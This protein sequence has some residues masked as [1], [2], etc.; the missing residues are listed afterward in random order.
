MA[1]G[2]RSRNWDSEFWGYIGIMGKKMEATI[3]YRDYV[4]VI[5]GLYRD[6]G[7]WNLV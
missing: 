3:F 7:E 2:I 4:E 1:G 5:L 6:N